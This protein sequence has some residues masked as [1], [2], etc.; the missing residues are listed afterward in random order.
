MFP[1]EFTKAMPAAAA[2]PP[3]KA[4]GRFQNC[5]TVVQTPAAPMV[6]NTIESTVS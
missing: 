1:T 6:K 2:A 4:P 5:D 3:R